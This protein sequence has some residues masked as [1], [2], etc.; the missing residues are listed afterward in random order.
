MKNV[1]ARKEGRKA[2]CWKLCLFDLENA[3]DTEKDRKKKNYK[4]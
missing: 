4:S 2:T 3:Q 1:K